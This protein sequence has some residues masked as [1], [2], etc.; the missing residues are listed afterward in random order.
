MMQEC[1]T[2][3]QIA[4]PSSPQ[5][6][7][8]KALTQIKYRH[9]RIINIWPEVLWDKKTKTK[10]LPRTLSQ[11]PTVHFRAWT[12]KCTYLSPSLPPSQL[13]HNVKLL[14]PGNATSVE[15]KKCFIV[16]LPFTAAVSR[17]VPPRKKRALFFFLSES[18]SICV[19][20]QAH[21]RHHVQKQINTMDPW[22]H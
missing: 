18:I 17:S 9:I 10:N 5:H 11:R 13:P 7:E 4:S 2:D 22:E 15:D 21:V 1:G 20:L 8:T 14:L 6:L 3:L 16:F 19:H 12:H